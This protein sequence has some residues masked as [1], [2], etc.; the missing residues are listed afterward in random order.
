MNTYDGLSAFLIVG[1]MAVASPAWSAESTARP[2]TTPTHNPMMGETS[3]MGQNTTNSNP[4][5]MTNCRPHMDGMQK[6][7]AIVASH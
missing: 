2:T 3:G 4:S 6:S 5:M 1:G 7:L